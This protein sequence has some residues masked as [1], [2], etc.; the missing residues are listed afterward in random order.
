MDPVKK[1]KLLEKIYLDDKPFISS[2]STLEEISRGSITPTTMRARK[3]VSDEAVKSK[4]GRELDKVDAKMRILQEHHH[5]FNQSIDAILTRIR[6]L[7]DGVIDSGELTKPAKDIRDLGEKFIPKI[8]VAESYIDELRKYLSFIESNSSLFLSYRDEYRT[9]SN[10]VIRF[11]INVA[12]M[13]SAQTQELVQIYSPLPVLEKSG[14]VKSKGSSRGSKDSQDTLR[15]L[16]PLEALLISD[17]IGFCNA[18]KQ[19]TVL[20]DIFARSEKDGRIIIKD[21]KPEVHTILLYMQQR[22]DISQIIVIDPSNSKF[23]QHLVSNA[24]RLSVGDSEKVEIIVPS[25][26]LRIYENKGE[27]GPNPSQYRDCTDIAVKLAFGL[28]KFEGV[29]DVKSIGSL[30]VVKEV[31]NLE[32]INGNLF[33]KA[34]D[35]IAR[36]RQ[37]SDDTARARVNDLLIKIDKQVQSIHLYSDSDD[38]YDEVF[39]ENTERFGLSYT[40][41]QYMEGIM[42]FLKVYSDNKDIIVDIMSQVERQLGGNFGNDEGG[43]V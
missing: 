19:K 25:Q 22:G 13:T 33:F 18:V 42:D 12:D 7:S 35:A 38:L 14:S 2:D 41:D 43:E 5:E 37:A 31:T 36:I 16:H 29:V 3:F 8:A 28:N 17:A 24:S 11:G 21:D 4:A 23:S 20:V 34:E 27:T 26:E 9:D 1:A 6:E 39:R 32:V 30:D 40:Y 10:A 15:A